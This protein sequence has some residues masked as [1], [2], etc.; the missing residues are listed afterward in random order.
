MN[1]VRL[2]SPFDRI[3]FIKSN[4]TFWIITWKKFKKRL[5]NYS[6]LSI[7]VLILGLILSS[8]NEPINPFIILG[9]GFLILSLYMGLIILNSWISFNKKVKLVAD[10]F[11]KL[12]SN[13]IFELS[14]DSVK[15]WDFEKHFDFK[16]SVFTHYSIYKGYIVLFVNNSMVGGY[17]FNKKGS[18]ID[19]YDKILELV[20]T[21]LEYKD[22]K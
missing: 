13:F 18:E 1:I 15:Y 11:D 2:D 19:K 17:L 8:E 22:I 10:K 7:I 14:N 21:K 3:D 4:K 20:K 16:W 6:I 9:I 12:K 5:I